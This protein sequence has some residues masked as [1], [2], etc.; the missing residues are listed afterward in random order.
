MQRCNA[1]NDC[2][3]LLLSQLTMMR[4]DIRA[5]L[6]SLYFLSLNSDKQDRGEKSI[7]LH[8]SGTY[9]LRPDYL[10]KSILTE[11]YLNLP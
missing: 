6:F 8:T 1:S 7:L 5:F 11:Y 2:I 9:L 10:S 3:I 4:T